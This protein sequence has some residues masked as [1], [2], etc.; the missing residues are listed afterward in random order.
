MSILATDQTF[1]RDSLARLGLKLSHLRLMAALREHRQI[2]AA[3]A[4]LAISQPAASRLAVELEG[5]LGMPIYQRHARGIHLT[6]IGMH[7]AERSVRVLR[8][9]DDTARD[10]A[11]MSDG[12]GG[13]VS[14][15]AVTGAAL[16]RVLP[17]VK[18]TRVTHPRITV[19]IM[20]DTSDVL[21]EATLAGRLDFYIG[22]VPAS[23][24]PRQFVAH[25]IGDEPI[26]LTV[27]K[28]HPLTRRPSISLHDCV[29]YD[30]IL[31]PEGTLLRRGLERYLHRKKVDFPR[32]VLSTSSM[33]LTLS[34]ITQTNAI[35]P[36]AHAVA[37]FFVR[38]E[39]AN[40][41][42]TQLLI[43]DDFRIEPYGLVKH[44]VRN[45]SP[46]S[47]VF[48]DLILKQFPAEDLATYDGQ[49]PVAHL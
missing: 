42:I 9:L 34:L 3:A 46:A 5:I 7:L 15:G 24:N 27:R 13:S 21:A 44:S 48:F 19:N 22:R 25:T 39:G 16:E 33:L 12:Q 2:S 31:Q 49:Q 37:N 41:A 20:V 8:E 40:E 47:Q 23:E 1:R 32:K 28:D 43:A 17:V 30:W 18:Q 45:L 36:M 4:Q 6:E 35:A 38:E 11:E 10:I 14:I 29:E 26:R